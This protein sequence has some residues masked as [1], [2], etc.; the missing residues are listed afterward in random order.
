MI[1]KTHCDLMWY[2]HTVPDCTDIAGE[3]RRCRVCLLGP[4]K[5]NFFPAR[6]Q[7]WK[8]GFS[9]RGAETQNTRV[10]RSAVR[11]NCLP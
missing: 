8:A 1:C 10:T 11:D 7:L 5:A 6:R 4:S 3:N 2:I 9:H